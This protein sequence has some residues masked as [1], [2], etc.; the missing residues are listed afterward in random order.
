MGIDSLYV[1]NAKH[2]NGYLVYQ[3]TKDFWFTIT[4]WDVLDKLILCTNQD[5][6]YW[7]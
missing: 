3:E 4:Q 6:Y 7:K 1:S 2:I 5:S